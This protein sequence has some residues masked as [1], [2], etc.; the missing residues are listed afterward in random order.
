[1]DATL[2]LTTTVTALLSATGGGAIVANILKH[3]EATM[4]KDAAR[5]NAKDERA[6]KVLETRVGKLEVE[7]EECHREREADRNERVE[8]L[9]RYAV[10]QHQVGLLEKAVEQSGIIRTT[11]K[12]PSA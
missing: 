3:R 1:M 7:V 6:F 5:D 10:L 2:I 9:E 8:C 4:D 11:P 12:P